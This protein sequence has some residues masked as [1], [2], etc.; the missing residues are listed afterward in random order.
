MTVVVDVMILMCPGAC[1]GC[2]GFRRR[3]PSHVFPV[4]QPGGAAGARPAG[5]CDLPE[6]GVWVHLVSEV[7]AGHRVKESVEGYD[8]VSWWSPSGGAGIDPSLQKVGFHS[9]VK[10]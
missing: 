4:W 9:F 10:Y 8:L 2:A 5:H 7:G 3:N 1:G 6:W